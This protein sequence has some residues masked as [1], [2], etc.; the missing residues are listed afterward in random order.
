MRRWRGKG[1][2]LILISLGKNATI[3]IEQRHIVIKIYVEREK[4]FHNAMYPLSLY[5]FLFL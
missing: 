1:K 2:L 3:E 5:P 4:L